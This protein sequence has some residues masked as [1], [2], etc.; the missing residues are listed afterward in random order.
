MSGLL[1][2]H[3]RPLGA[4]SLAAIEARGF[5]AEEFL[6]LDLGVGEL[7]DRPDQ[8]AIPYR[9]QGQVVAIRTGAFTKG[10]VGL[11]GGRWL[12]M[13]VPPLYNVDCLRDASLADEPLIVVE[14]ELACWA[15]L[16]AGFRRCIGLPTSLAKGGGRQPHLEAA[17]DLIRD[18][19]RAVICTFDDEHGQALRSHIADTIGAVRCQ[20]VSY[21]QGCSDL[22]ATLRKF[23]ARGVQETIQ[24]ARWYSMPGFYSMSE[25]PEPPVN[26][27]YGTGIVGL[28]DHMR[29]RRGD[30]TIISGVPGAGKTT[31]ANEVFSRLALARGFRTIWASFEQRTKPDHRSSLRTFHAGKPE[32][33]MSPAEK[34]AADA[35][36]DEHF[37]FLVP[38]DETEA[39]L[40]WLL[41]M[42]GAAVTR[43]DPFAIVIDPWNALEHRRPQGMTTTEYTGVSIERIKR[44]ARKRR[45]HVAVVAHP[46]KMQRNRD[47]EYPKPTLYD[48]A[49]SAHW[50][51]KADLGVMVWRKTGDTEAE[52]AVV[53]SRYYRELG[54]PG[55]VKGIYDQSTARLTITDDGG[56]RGEV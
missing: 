16:S 50:A 56:M 11:Q 36:I 10:I 37:R 5:D 12:G 48:I 1:Q 44:F 14:G 9:E 6:K 17:A 54:T 13:S 30:L 55:A 27:A 22:P 33:I 39:S 46:A 45:V 42:L 8:L 23:K 52:I 49:D 21:P 3:I 15:A 4:E 18:I 47:G 43:F 41:D 20:W 32:T 51:N 34:A 31:F 29:L 26:P 25:L 38:D 19:P 2:N 35:W 24:R 40:D 7:A 53:K 28:D